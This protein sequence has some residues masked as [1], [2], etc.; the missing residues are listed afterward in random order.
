MTAG[1]LTGVQLCGA[2]WDA[3]TLVSTAGEAAVPVLTN[4]RGEV[5]GL[6]VRR[7]VEQEPAG[8]TRGRS[9]GVRA[10]GSAVSG[11]NGR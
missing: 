5:R 8:P 10:T 2:G 1:F 6:T 4:E 11:A 3:T 7:L 9:G